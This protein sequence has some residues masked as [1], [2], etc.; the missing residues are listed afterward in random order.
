MT[1][2]TF[3][4]IN[5]LLAFFTQ[6]AQLD[7]GSS[8]PLRATPQ[9]LGYEISEEELAKEMLAQIQTYPAYRTVLEDNLEE[10]EKIYCPDT[11]GIY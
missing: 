8:I 11:Y 5:P 7:P 6:D 2:Q 1:I 3:C 9:D 4:L 10:F